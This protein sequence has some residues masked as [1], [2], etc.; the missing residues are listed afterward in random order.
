MA[1]NSSL[2]KAEKWLL[3]YISAFVVIIAVVAC[4]VL[5]MNATPVVNIPSPVMPNPNARD[6]YLKAVK[7][8]VPYQI[9]LSTGKSYPLYFSD[10]ELLMNGQTFGTG[11]GIAATF[12][13]LDKLNHLVPPPSLAKMQALAQAKMKGSSPQPSLAEMQ[14]LSRLNAPAFAA[15]RAGFQAGLPGNV[16]PLLLHPFPRIRPV[17]RIGAISGD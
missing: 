12:A 6:S 9:A 17:S 11:P 5:E 13:S 1:K 14:A 3:F 15:L 7:A 16:R 10:L 8:F 2:S 4:W